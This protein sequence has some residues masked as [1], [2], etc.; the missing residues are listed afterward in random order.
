MEEYAL[1]AIFFITQL[2]LQSIFYFLS[3]LYLSYTTPL[4]I[5]LDDINTA[6]NL[7][8]QSNPNYSS[9]TTTLIV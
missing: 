9:Y 5:V 2:C 1:K 3:L 4:F 8:N 7:Y 6:T